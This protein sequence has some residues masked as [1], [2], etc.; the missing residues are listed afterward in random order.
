MKLLS[1][2]GTTAMFLVGGEIIAHGIPSIEHTLS[3]TT[4][5]LSSLAPFGAQVFAGALNLIAI[6]ALGFT[7]G[8]VLVAVAGAVKKLRS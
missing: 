1:F 5:F 3:E 7:V 2:L 4:K 6:I 8:L